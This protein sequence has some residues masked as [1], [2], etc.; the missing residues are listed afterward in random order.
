MRV[1]PDTGEGCLSGSARK[2][3]IKFMLFIGAEI[4]SNCDSGTEVGSE[5]GDYVQIFTDSKRG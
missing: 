1:V 5:M 4:S 3:H 2:S